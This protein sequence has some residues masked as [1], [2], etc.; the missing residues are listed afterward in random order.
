MIK[1]SKRTGIETIFAAINRAMLRRHFHALHVAGTDH[2]ASLDR[3]LPIIFIGNHSS[4]WDGLLEFYFSHDLF[5]VDAF[6]MMEEKQMRRY[7]F[8]RWIG[9]FSVDRDI[10]REG[11]ISLQYAASLFNRPN[12]VLWIYPQGTM[13]PNDYRPLGF[14]TG[15]GRLVQMLGKTQIVPV[16]HRYEFL[17]EQR[18]ES[19]T[20][21][22][23]PIPADGANDPKEL[24]RLLEE[25]V[26]LMLD[27]LR[28]RVVQGETGEFTRVLSGKAS[29]NVLYDTVR[30]IEDQ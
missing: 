7:K 4:W 27:Q 19:F 20:T 25:R 1:A 2:V 15:A 6:L 22:G 23:S 18:P 17:M 3:S 5:G 21:F 29:T 11:V 14:Y 9:A 26:T 24:T 8:F 12:R 28:S 16:V 13:R 30:R 10:P